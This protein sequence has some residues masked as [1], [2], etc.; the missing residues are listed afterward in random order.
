MMC[1]GQF[2]PGLFSH[3][4]AEKTK[5]EQQKKKPP[6]ALARCAR[7]P[8]ATASASRPQHLFHG[9]LPS[10]R[11]SPVRAARPLDNP[12]TLARGGRALVRLAADAVTWAGDGCAGA[13]LRACLSAPVACPT[14]WAGH[15]ER[16][17]RRSWA[18][19]TL[20]ARCSLPDGGSSRAAKAGSHGADRGQLHA[21]AKGDHRGEMRR[22]R[23][24]PERLRSE[25]PARPAS[26]STPANSGRIEAGSSTRRLRGLIPCRFLR[27]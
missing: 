10:R 25:Y 8:R 18:G 1:T 12:A 7:V 11:K 9:V 24:L 16:R 26:P 23:L 14:R 6:I 3:C 2:I 20:P 17:G 15:V 19:W 5:P 21:Q 22:R 27:F 13:P 4:L